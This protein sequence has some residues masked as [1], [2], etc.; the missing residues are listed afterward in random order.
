[1][2]LQTRPSAHPIDIEHGRFVDDDHAEEVM[3]EVDS[4]LRSTV[5]AVLHLYEVI[6]ATPEELMI[7]ED[8][9]RPQGRPASRTLES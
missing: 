3:V 9:G 7:F 5:D 8:C 4:G 2:L 6:W 1:M